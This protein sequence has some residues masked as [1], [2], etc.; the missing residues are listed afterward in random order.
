MSDQDELPP[1]VP[2]KLFYRIG[3]AA[4]IVGVEPHVL[5]YWE[6]EFKMRPTRSPSGQR[7][8][9]RK[10]LAKFLRIRKLLHDEG[11]TIA[12]ARKALSETGAPST[13]EPTSAASSVNGSAALERIEAIRS[14]IAR[15]RKEFSLRGPTGDQESH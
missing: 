10:D 14:Q 8:F 6:G 2:D 7:M 3:E 13:T 5:R 4:E 9:K 15:V 12:G 1:D 11:F